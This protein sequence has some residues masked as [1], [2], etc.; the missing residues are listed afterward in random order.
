[1]TEL[2][3]IGVEDNRLIVSGDDGRQFQV[4]IDDALRDAVRPKPQERRTAPKVAPREIQQL[5]RA[6]HSI[7]EIVTMTGA[8][9]ADV[10]RFEAPI[11][12]ERD[13]MVEQ[14]R[15]VSVRVQSDVDPMGSD[16]AT[17]GGVLDE[18]LETINARDIAWDGWKDPET[19]WH[20]KLS[21]TV[22]SLEREA[23]WTFEPKSRA[24]SP[25]NDHATTLSQQGELESLAAPTLRAVQQEGEMVAPIERSTARMAPT[26]EAEARDI[27]R[28]PTAAAPRIPGNETADLLEALRR[29]RGEREPLT[30]QDPELEAEYDEQFPAPEVPQ[31]HRPPIAFTPRQG[32]L[33][34]DS[35]I[36]DPG[37]LPA[38]N[39][40]SGMTG[41]VDRIRRGSH[42]KQT[43]NGP[44][45]VDVPLHGFDEVQDSDAREERPAAGASSTAARPERAKAAPVTEQ[46]PEQPAH[47]G[48]QQRNTTASLG[49]KR[50]RKAMPSWD[51][52]VFG[53]KRDD[54]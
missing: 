42:G 34:E 49:K 8:E 41:G 51:E 53:T 11:R 26:H 1:M 45:I 40:T 54:E 9:K 32:G 30:F 4:P 46:K 18:R 37:A 38:P 15:G 22:D 13:Y 7:D 2:R 50:S 27:P 12:A 23:I 21:F 16:G 29:R 36:D 43:K 14:A 48:P 6:G 52:I 3:F 25:K 19:G 24:L 44:R 39:R 5:I 10:E 17:F 47:P 28:H 35:G 33:R 20:I 31:P